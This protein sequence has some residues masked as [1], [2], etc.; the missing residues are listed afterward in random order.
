[1]ESH[2]FFIR[3]KANTAIAQAHAHISH[4][5]KSNMVSSLM[6]LRKTQLS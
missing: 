3:H 2:L 5:S 6:K 1:M 4:P